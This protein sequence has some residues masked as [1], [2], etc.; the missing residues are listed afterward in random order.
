MVQE[1]ADVDADLD[2]GRQRARRR[3]AEAKPGAGANSRRHL[4]AHRMVRRHLSPALA[5]GAL[6][7]LAGVW[8]ATRQPAS[9]G[10]EPI[11][12]TMAAPSLAGSAA[13]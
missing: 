12:P 7:I 6:L 10:S 9:T 13:D 3:Y 8:L 11:A 2:A 1:S 5:V 4:Q